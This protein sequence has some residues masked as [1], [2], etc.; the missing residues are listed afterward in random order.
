MSASAGSSVWASAS[1]W[2]EGRPRRSA[3]YFHS[4]GS[5]LF[6]SLYDGAGPCRLGVIVCSSWGFEADHARNLAHDAALAV[7]RH[8]GAAM[9]FHYPGYGDSCDPGE[10]ATF[11]T[12]VAAA[13]DAA[14]CARDCRPD[15]EWSFLG[16]ML[17][18]SI[19]ALASVSAGIER[20]LLVQP[21]LDPEAYFANLRHR[22]RRGTLGMVDANQLV[23]GYPVPVVFDGASG[24]VRES[25]RVFRGRGT[26]I[27]Y[28][29]SAITVPDG[30]EEIGVP[31]RWSFGAKRHQE[32]ED[33]LLG[34]LDR[35]ARKAAPHS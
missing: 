16:L 12:M 20:L 5:E 13:V 33:G 29:S 25:L 7:S 9:L 21:E 24:W 14:A 35:A 31:G 11:E 22:A 8:G 27:R 2:T 17:G 32:L 28:E 15:V 10:P 19:A 26:V 3:C 30:F 6:G 4:R 23:F 18:A 1:S 34:Y